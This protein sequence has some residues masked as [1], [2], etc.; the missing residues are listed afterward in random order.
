MH[1]EF[2]YKKMLEDNKHC[3]YIPIEP[4]DG[5]CYAYLSAILLDS[6]LVNSNKHYPQI[7]LQK[8]LHAV[9]RKVF[10]GKYIDKFNDKSNDKSNE[11]SNDKC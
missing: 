7:F 9:D 1:T 4:E 8:C 5:D 2:K 6:V 10:L 11:K 3:K